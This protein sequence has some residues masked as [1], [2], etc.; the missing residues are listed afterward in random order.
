MSLGSIRARVPAE[1]YTYTFTHV[2]AY[3]MEPV[4]NNNNNN[5]CIGDVPVVRPLFWLGC[6]CSE[7]D[8]TS[9]VRAQSELQLTYRHGLLSALI[10]YT[11]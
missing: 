6:S 5:Q 11:G 1:L 9:S 3:C 7:G 8:K 2:K 10:E 4:N